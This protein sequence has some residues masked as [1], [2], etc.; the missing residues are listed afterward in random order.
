MYRDLPHPA[1]GY[2]GIPKGVPL[3]VPTEVLN[4]PI[5]YTFR[6]ADGS[7]NNVHMPTLGMAGLPYVRN[8]TTS[9]TF[10]HHGT[11]PSAETVFDELLKRDGFVEHP[12]GCRP[13]R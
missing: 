9:N 6:A 12:G 10:L 2:L 3:P 8:V 13:I 4:N 1:I 7:N 11:Y 5:P